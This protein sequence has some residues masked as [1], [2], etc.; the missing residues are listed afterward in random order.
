MDIRIVPTDDMLV[1]ARRSE[2]KNANILIRHEYHRKL[3]RLPGKKVHLVNIH[4][5]TTP[6]LRFQFINE[7]V[8]GEGVYRLD[9]DTRLGC[10]RCSPHMGRD[11][12]CEYTKKC[13][14][15][16][17]AAV[18]EASIPAED[19]PAYEQAKANGESLMD[20]PKRFPYFCEGTKTQRAGTLVPF[21]LNSRNCIYEC[22]D[23]CRCGPNCRNKNVQFG[24]VIEL[25]I[26][27]TDPKKGRGWG[28]RSKEKIY[29]G[30]FIDT[31][32]GEIITDAEANRRE[33]ASDSHM[34]ASYLYSL[35]KHQKD[36]NGDDVIPDEDIYV[37][38]GEFMGGPTKFMNHSCEPNCYQYTVSYNKHDYRIYDL[39]F[40]AVRDIPAGE[41]LTFDYLD[42]DDDPE[43]PK[44]VPQETLNMIS[45]KKDGEKKTGTKKEEN[46]KPPV[47]CHCGTP[48][49]RKWL[50]Q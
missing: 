9:D 48:S 34:K 17:Y 39:A 32:R 49:C 10:R 19:W 26:F 3:K 33:N 40:F 46:Q 13:D 36:S 37:V 21:Y 11:I 24:R 12:G 25:E 2:I 29:K 44:E 42:K 38:D 35:D 41:E 8:L 15:L 16:E 31:Y 18:H 14:C 6:S 1:T 45:P 22:N 47:P 23:K 28:L 20:F 4:D 50:W 43:V 5:Y 27:L 30:Q 7:Y